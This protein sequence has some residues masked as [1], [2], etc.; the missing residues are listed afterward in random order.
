MHY[1]PGTA[2]VGLAPLPV[3]LIHVYR[4]LGVE[5]FFAAYESA[6]NR[7]L[8][9]A[10][11]QARIR[12][13]LPTSARW[14]LDLARADA[15]SGLESLLRLRLHLLGIRLECQVRIDGVGR[16][17]FVIEK[18]LILEV[19]GRANHAGAERRHHDLARDA[20]ASARGYETLRFDYA[21]VVHDWDAVVRAI[22]PALA[23][24][25]A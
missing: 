15:E 23:R 4:C 12:R 25:R 7:R 18:R 2:A 14:L 22:I 11:D 9:S 24:A 5:A 3:V 10:A 19:D 8:L 21:M 1:S 20:A 16:V 17:D 13:E 6:W